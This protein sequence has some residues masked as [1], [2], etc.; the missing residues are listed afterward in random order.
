MNWAQS[1]PFLFFSMNKDL[2]KEIIVEFVQPLATQLDLFV[3]GVSIKG[4]MKHRI[5][6]V[7]IDKPSG[8]TIED[9]SKLQRL[10]D[11]H[12]ES[13]EYANNI[14]SIEVS[15]PG[16]DNPLTF[17]WQIANHIT[18]LC[19]IKLSEQTLHGRII[20]FDENGSFSVSILPP[21]R[22]GVKQTEGETKTFQFSEIDSITII[23][24]IR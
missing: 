9:C 13:F 5:V 11:E 4:T 8:V 18:R 20:S 15:S 7:F 12:F 14:T 10:M 3:V 6:S 22:K 17:D 2:S 24:E 23:P 19:D 21:K 16:F 1:S